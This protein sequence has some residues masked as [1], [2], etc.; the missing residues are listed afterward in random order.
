MRHLNSPLPMLIPIDPGGEHVECWPADPEEVI[1]LMS[2]IMDVKEV[3]RV[4]KPNSAMSE[5]VSHLRRLSPASRGP[6]GGLCFR[7]VLCDIADAWENIGADVH[8]LSGVSAK[9]GTLVVVF[10]PAN[11]GNRIVE[12]NCAF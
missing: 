3:Y 2:G 6:K 12:I 1:E 8:V 7:N 5:L 9:K 4:C 10:V 11:V